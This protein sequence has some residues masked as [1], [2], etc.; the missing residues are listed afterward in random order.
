MSGVDILGINK[1]GR[2]LLQSYCGMN[3]HPEGV[4][5][6]RQWAVSPPCAGLQDLAWQIRSDN[7][8]HM[9]FR[10]S[11]DHQAV[12]YTHLT[13]PTICSV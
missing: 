13:L 12:S 8:G 11:G 5:V 2:R 6:D 4:D 7:I 9:V 3:H 1:M 10:I